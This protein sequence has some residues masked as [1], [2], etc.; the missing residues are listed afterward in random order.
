MLMRRFADQFPVWMRPNHPMLRY[1]LGYTPRRPASIRYSRIILSALLLGGLFAG[2]YVVA[3]DLFR[4][5]P[6]EQPF[7]QM[8][9]NIIFWPV[10]AL[11][12]I[13]QVAVLILT[14]NTIGDEKRR[15]NWDNVKATSHGVALALRARWSAV[16]FYRL[17]G[18]LALLVLVRLLL[19]G[20]I[21]FDLT[22]FRGEYLNYLTGSIE[23]AIPL[24]VGV[25]LLAL[26]MTASLLL[27]VTS[28]GFD[29]AFGLLVSTFVQQRTYTV[30]AQ[31]ALVVIRVAVIGVLLFAF[32]QFR[33][34][35]L[36][37]SDL[38]VWLML[39]AFAAVGDWGIS[40][41]Y[42]GFYGAEVWA[43]VPY[44]VFIG[45]AL[46]V[47]VMVQAAL[48]DALLALAIYLGERSD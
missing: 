26:T 6:F 37:T 7:S 35:L 14:I 18:L 31:I 23:P 29:A 43:T 45:L 38:I 39:A 21:L 46:L 34:N 47:F 12:V 2:G 20:G 11:Q 40:F 48:T 32:T 28:L 4:Q 27:P 44:G 5:N 19:I 3:S 22:A 17:R 15:Q 25:L 42:L 36:D 8:L 16:I 30:L 24:P 13:M 1:S 10:F 33:M 9:S 41:L